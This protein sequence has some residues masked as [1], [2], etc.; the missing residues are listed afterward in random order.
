MLN[1]TIP[2]E[3][4]GQNLIVQE[5]LS[6]VRATVGLIEVAFTFDSY[7]DNFTVKKAHFQNSNDANAFT[8]DIING[9][10]E[11]PF[12]V[13]F[14]KGVI[15]IAIEGTNVNGQ[16]ERTNPVDIIKQT[17][18][19][20][21]GRNCINPTPD[22]FTQFVKAVNESKLPN[23]PTEDGTYNLQV[24]VVDGVPTYSWVTNQ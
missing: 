9:K 11:V 22:Q 12:E 16:V 18:T 2:V 19:I 13:L 10:C 6:S 24:S 15:S 21:K 4:S 7:W 17:E 3:V 14:Y 23:P 5:K 8:K 20:I 1:K